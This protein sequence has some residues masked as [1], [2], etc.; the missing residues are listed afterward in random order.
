MSENALDIEGFIAICDELSRMSGKDFRAVIVPQVGALLRACINRT[1]GKK[2]VTEGMIA[3]RVSKHFS[4]VEFSDGTIIST[5][6]KANHAEMYFD[7]STYDRYAGRWPKGSRKPSVDGGKS[8]HQMNGGR[9]WSNE[10]WARF[11]AHSR[12]RREMIQKTM[13]EKLAAR[14]LAKKSWVQIAD[15]LGLD[16]GVPK[17]ISGARDPKGRPF[18]EGLATTLVE[19]A[20]FI[21]EITNSNPL[22]VGRLDGREILAGAMRDREKAFMID[23]EKGVFD[24]VE[25]RAKRYPGVFVN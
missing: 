1:G 19:Q 22:V 24:D 5:F 6:K 14:G 13:R 8:W 2:K 9:H 16:L 25:R 15:D 4:Y 11:Q 12:Q 17:W 7:Q 20:A 23:M 3:K 10:R 18:K 21:V